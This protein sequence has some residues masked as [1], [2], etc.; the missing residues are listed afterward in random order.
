MPS[1]AHRIAVGVVKISR[2]KAHMTSQTA[3]ANQIRK[4]RPQEK[5]HPPQGMRRKVK[6]TRHA[7]TP[8]P[9]WRFEPKDVEAR[10]H[11]I[12]S[13]GGAYTYQLLGVHW[14]FAAWAA[15]ELKISVH[16]PVYPLA[17]E[18]NWRDT[19]PALTELYASLLDDGEVYLAGD[20]A[21]GGLSLALAQLAIA[22]GLRAPD[23]LV[24]ISPWLDVTAKDEEMRR[25][26]RRDPMLS[27]DGL[28]AAGR[29]WAGNDDPAR[30]EVSPLHGSLEG[31]G[32]TLVLTGTADLLNV[33]ARR[34]A[35]K[36]REQ[37]LALTI[38]EEEGLLHDYPLFPIPEGRNA[39]QQ[40]ASFLKSN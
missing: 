13:H 3:L 8:F 22:G 28:C 16:V 36:A 40:I 27:V 20:S 1:L 24:L 25:A 4:S 32:R 5:D 23:A 10:G 34:F 37:G 12:F 14:Q 2:R 15:R 38:H 11:L 30:P 19:L 29:M 26:E 9:V 17:P 39:R 21:G 18:H 7:D 35:A 6:I 31:I 33:D